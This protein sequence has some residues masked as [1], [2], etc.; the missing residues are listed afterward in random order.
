M[1]PFKPSG[2][3]AVSPYFLVEDAEGFVAWLKS[4]F[5][6]QELRRYDRQDG[7]IMHAELRIEDS[8]IMLSSSTPEFPPTQFCM[9]VYV[10]DA[11]YIYDKAL[12]LGC[13][14]LK[15]PMIE[16]G[17]TDLRGTFKDLAGNLWSVGTQKG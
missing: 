4:L 16:E 2:Y 1:T 9:H 12:A 13:E 3:N 17:D 8:V 14:G 11:Q 15:A 5:G 10:A 6:A 7:S